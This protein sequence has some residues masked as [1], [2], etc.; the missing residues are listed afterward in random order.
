MSY[1]GS[2]EEGQTRFIQTTHCFTTVCDIR[3]KR[4]LWD[5]L[6]GFYSKTQ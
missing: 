1:K 4:V 2:G 3:L 5:K 6:Y